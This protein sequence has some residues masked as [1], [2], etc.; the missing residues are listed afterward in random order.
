MD[1]AK[2]ARVTLDRHVVRGVGKHHRGAFLAHQQG[3]GSGI[4]GVATQHP[5]PAE[6]PFITE[7]ADWRRRRNRG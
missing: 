5:M 2:P 7:S 6:D 1:R 4:E 3:E